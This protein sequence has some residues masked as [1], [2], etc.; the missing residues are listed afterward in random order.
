MNAPETAAYLRIDPGELFRLMRQGEIPFK[1]DPLASPVFDRKEIDAWA[2]RRILGLSGK[3]LARYDADRTSGKRNEAEIHVC[4]LIS[5]ERIRLGMPSKTKSGVLSD[6]TLFADKAGLLYDPRDLLDSLRSREELCSTGLAGGVAIL[7]PRYHD[8][9]LVPGP[10]LVL[11]RTSRPI[12]FGAPDDAPT[13]LFFLLVCTDDRLH[14]HS[15]AR[16]CV[17]FSKTGLLREIRERESPAEIL[18]AMRNAETEAA[19]KAAAG[20]Q[21]KP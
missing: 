12:P 7:H 2:S 8:P 15:L 5:E 9:Y 18:A 13:D 4:E 10:F 11:A 17:M 3:R 14:L 20:Q 16:L 19:A 21:R 6:V 1:G